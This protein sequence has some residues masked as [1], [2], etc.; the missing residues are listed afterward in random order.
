VHCSA[1]VGV[2]T[3]WFLCR[4]PRRGLH[5]FSTKQIDD[6]A[7]FKKSCSNRRPSALKVIMKAKPGAIAEIYWPQEMKSGPL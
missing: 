1:W 3:L 7:L 5:I 2:I 6:L 4:N